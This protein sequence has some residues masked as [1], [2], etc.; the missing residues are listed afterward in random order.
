MDNL[1]SRQTRMI[2]PDRSGLNSFFLK[3]YSYMG[4]ALLL[5]S[6]TTFVCVTMFP[7]QTLAL[8]SN[9]VTTLILFA[10]L[11]GIVWVASRSAMQNPAKAFGLMMAYSIV[12]GLFFTSLVMFLQPKSI[13]LA[14]I[15]TAALFAGMAL[16]GVTT[17]RDMSKLGTILFG[18]V[19]AL[20][21]GGLLNLFMGGTILYLGLSVIGVIVFA[22]ITAYDMNNLKKMYVQ[23]AGSAQAE[24]GVAVMGALNLYID[25]INLFTYILRLF[26][27]SSNNN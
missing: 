9:L 26:A 6:L 8:T 15:T 7:M 27:F 21:I 18:A 2:N 1:N 3:V 13:I 20:I 17:K 22:I 25:F 10:V 4:M 5:T 11:M 16:Y 19:F 14:F 24:Q 12:M 23:V